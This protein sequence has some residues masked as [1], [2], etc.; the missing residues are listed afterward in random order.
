M[1]MCTSVCVCVLCGAMDVHLSLYVCFSGCGCALVFTGT[2]K[3]C[4]H[5]ITLVCVLGFATP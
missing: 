4:K 2:R 5:N 3:F 1:W